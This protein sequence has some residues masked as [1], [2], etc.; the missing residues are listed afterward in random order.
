MRNS[1]KLFLATIIMIN[2]FAPAFAAVNPEEI[3]GIWTFDEG[4]GD[5]TS[6]L[7]GNE[8]DGIIIGATDWVDGKSGKA[9]EFSGGYVTVEQDELMDLETFSMTCWLNVPGALA[10]Y[11]MVMGKEAWPNRNYSMWILPDRINLGITDVA[12]ADQ[13]I[14]GAVVADGEWHHVAGTY[15]R[16]FLRVYVDGV[17]SAQKALTTEPNICNAPFMIGA[18]PPGGGG[19]VNGVIDEVGLFSVALEEEDVKRIVEDGLSFFVTPV[20]PGG[21]LCGVWGGLKSAY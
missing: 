6:D 4:N 14:Q 12:G 15:D 13:Q 9:I 18:Q 5:S 7:S 16:E 1:V 10:T 17:Q 19:P 3:L 21:K 2:L 11:Q 20:E 8:R